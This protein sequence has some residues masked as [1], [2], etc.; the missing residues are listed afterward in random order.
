MFGETMS[1]VL[2]KDGQKL[3]SDVLRRL[4]SCKLGYEEAGF[5][6]FCA[7]TGFCKMSNEDV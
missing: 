2:K 1:D 5:V 4:R 3:A 7:Y 6:L